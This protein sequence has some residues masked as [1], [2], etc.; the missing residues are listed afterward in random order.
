MI[1]SF[2]MKQA[3][4]IGVKNYITLAFPKHTYKADNLKLTTCMTLH[5]PLV[6]SDIHLHIALSLIREF[7]SAHIE[8][9]YSYYL[10]FALCRLRIVLA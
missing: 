8:H 2:W 5:H 1:D 3:F 10:N 6:G 7:V 4:A 9:I